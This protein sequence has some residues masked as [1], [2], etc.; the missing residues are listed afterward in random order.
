MIRLFHP[1]FSLDLA[2]SDF[3]L[4]GCVKSALEE[5]EFP[6]PEDLFTGIQELLSEI[7]RS[8]LKLVFYHWI[9][10]VQWVLDNDG[11]YFHE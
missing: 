11:D 1:P 6:G 9:E 10:P 3:W 2:P 5:Q 4:F 7:Q 8:E